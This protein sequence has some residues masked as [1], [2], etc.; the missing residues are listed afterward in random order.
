[1]LTFATCVALNMLLHRPLAAGK[2]IV[3][4]SS[5]S[6][7]TSLGITARVLNGNDDTRAY[8]TNKTELNRLR[9]LQFFGL[10]VW[11]LHSFSQYLLSIEANDVYLHDYLT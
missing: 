3:E 5:G 4:A 8:L 11:G 10:K 7:I 1:M 6:T 9:Q 2:T